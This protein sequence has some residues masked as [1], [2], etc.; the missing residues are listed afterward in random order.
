V[1][2]NPPETAP[3]DGSLILAYNNTNFPVITRWNPRS[4]VWMGTFTGFEL[5]G[6]LPLPTIDDEGNVK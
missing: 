3:K 6:W 4:G 1:K 2:L 5:H